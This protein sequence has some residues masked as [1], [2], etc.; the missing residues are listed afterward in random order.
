MQQYGEKHEK[1]KY[2][3]GGIDMIHCEWCEK[4]VQRVA[5]VRIGKTEFRICESCVQLFKDRKCIDCGCDVKIQNQDR[6]R[7]IQCAQEY[8]SKKEKEYQDEINK[9]PFTSEKDISNEEFEAWLC[10][11]PTDTTKV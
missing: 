3:H 6:G 11:R 8:N 4:E 10:K 5:K 2:Q 7:C 1:F 9:Y